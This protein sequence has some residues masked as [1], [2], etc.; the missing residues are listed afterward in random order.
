MTGHDKEAIQNALE[1]INPF[2]FRSETGRLYVYE[3][4][5][6]AYNKVVGLLFTEFPLGFV[7]VA[8]FMMK[9]QRLPAVQA[10]SYCGSH[11][12]AM[13]MD[14]AEPQT[15]KVVRH[16][17]RTLLKPSG[18]KLNESCF[19]EALRHL[20]SLHKQQEVK[21]LPINPYKL[22]NIMN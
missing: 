11:G 20:D 22:F 8:Q 6:A 10:R 18:C 1:A 2:M 13:I 17:M 21:E 7:D 15:G 9:Y 14:W 16:I 19:K 4:A 5:Q 3:T 12:Y